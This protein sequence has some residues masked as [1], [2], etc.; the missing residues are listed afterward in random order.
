MQGL[1]TQNST[2]KA[3]A[4]LAIVA[5]IGM[6]AIAQIYDFKLIDEIS[7]PQHVAPQV[8][9]MSS[10]QIKAHIWVT[11]ILDVLF[12]LAYAALFAGL[13]LRFL[14]SV[15]KILFIP[16]ILAA[17]TDLSEGVLQIMIFHGSEWA[18]LQKALVTPLKFGL[19]VI[20]VAI[21]LIALGVAVSRKFAAPKSSDPE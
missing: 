9:L 11:A 19:F 20:A 5:L 15:G 17:V 8:A 10:L 21:A 12:P 13:A 14:G 7:D 3:S 16:A 4:I 18:V 1:V 6:N 2:L